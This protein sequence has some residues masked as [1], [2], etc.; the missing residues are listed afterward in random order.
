V[1]T[2][3]AMTQEV[4]VATVGWA[5]CGLLLAAAFLTGRKRFDRRRLS[6]WTTEWQTVGPN[7]TMR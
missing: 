2:L 6:D 4:I 7:W 1:T 3:S 5:S